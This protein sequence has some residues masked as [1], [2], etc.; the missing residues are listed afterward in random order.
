MPK[1]NQALLERLE[2]ALGIRKAA[3]YVRIQQIANDRML[4]RHLAALVLASE[5]DINVHKYSNS[6]E[7]AQIRNSIGGLKSP[8]PSASIPSSSVE[9]VSRLSNRTKRVKARSKAKDNSVFVVH[10]RN[11]ALRKSLF[12]FLRSLG[13]NPLEWSKAVLLAKGANPQ[14]DSILDTAMSRVQ[15]VVVLFSPDDEARLKDEFCTKEEKWTEGKLQGQPRPNVIFEAG[16]ALGRHPGKTLLIQVG[17]VRGFTDI[18][19]KHLIRLTNDF[20]KRNDVANRLRKIGCDVDTRGSDWT[21]TG[22]FRA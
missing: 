15:A 18:A 8:Q 20:E 6:E 7:R 16:L 19:G 10:G 22:D 3:V 17:K 5:N 2:S 13:L 11:D 14:I 9:E 1:I 12:D 21:E 4:D